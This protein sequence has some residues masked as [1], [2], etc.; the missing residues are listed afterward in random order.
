MIEQR[1]FRDLVG[2]AL[3]HDEAVRADRHH[4]VTGRFFALGQHGEQ[5]RAVAVQHAAAAEERTVEGHRRQV[6]RCAG[7]DQGQAL[8]VAGSRGRVDRRLHLDFAAEP[9]REQRPE[10]PIDEAAGQ[11]LAVGDPALAFEIAAGDAAA[12]SHLLAV[13]DRQRKEVSARSRRSRGDDGHEHGV[14]ALAHEHGCVRLP[15]HDTGFELD[16]AC[17]KLEYRPRRVSLHGSKLPSKGIWL[18]VLA[19]GCGVCR[20]LAEP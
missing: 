7:T 9:R 3:D 13:F 6:Q 14:V 17:A 2:L 5:R 16:C 8:D 10:R 1:V 20:N 12:G 18:E 15:C 19:P 11:D 4:E